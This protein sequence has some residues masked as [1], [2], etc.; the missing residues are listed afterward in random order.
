MRDNPNHHWLKFRRKNLA[1]EIRGT[2]RI[3]QAVDSIMAENSQ[4]LS[5]KTRPESFSE[6]LDEY[7]HLIC[8][9]RSGPNKLPLALILS[10]QKIVTFLN[11]LNIAIRGSRL[12]EMSF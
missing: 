11:E 10:S 6:R 9:N 4:S 8:I 12:T 2:D 7:F 1:E 3:L 5:F